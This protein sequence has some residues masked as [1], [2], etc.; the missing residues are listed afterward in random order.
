MGALSTGKSKRVLK[1][2]LY[3]LL[4]FSGFFYILYF[5]LKASSSTPSEQIRVIGSSAVFPFAA[6]VAERFSFHQH[7]STPVVESVGTGVGFKVFCSGS[8]RNYPDVLTA[9][10][11]ISLTEKKLC[12]ARKSGDLYEIILGY[13]GIVLTHSNTIE[14]FSLTPAQ[15]YLGLA[16]KVP[17]GGKL[18]KN[19]AQTWKDVDPTLPDLKIR[20][21]GPSPAS[22]TR[23]T[24]IQQILIPGCKIVGQKFHKPLDC[25]RIRNDGAYVDIG[26]NENMIIQKVI[27]TPGAIGIVSFSYFD[28][29]LDRVGALQINRIDPTPQNIQQKR[30]ILSRPLF[31]YAKKNREKLLPELEAFI[32]E[33]TLEHVSG[34]QGYLTKRGLIPLMPQ[35][36]L[37]Q[38]KAI[39]AGHTQISLSEDLQH[40]P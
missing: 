33:F 40:A 38:Q 24:F 16:E 4:I 8:G 28:Q 11:P 34:Q 12:K 13:D 25:Q 14:S 39:K 10:R 19:P 5:V 32:Q 9:S 15:I 18:I 22:G 30:Y 3:V 36:Q 20:V 6:A 27:T 26:A 35:D 23:D 2:A 37:Q 31:I 21:L 1:Y 29:N 17:V 7:G